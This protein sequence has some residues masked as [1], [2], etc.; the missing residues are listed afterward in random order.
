MRR[1]RL[2]ERAVRRLDV[3]RRA[4]AGPEG[5]T[6]TSSPARHDAAR[7]LARVAAVVVVLVA[8][9]ADHPLHGEAAVVEVAVAGE[10]DRLEVLEQRRPVVPRR[11]A[12]DALD[13]VVAAQRRHRDDGTSRTPSRLARASRKLGL[14]L[15]EALLRRSRRG[16]SC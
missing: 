11:S 4:S 9:R 8:H 3:P 16:P 14:D 12:S 1:H 6:T 15:A 10:L 5:R 2:V 13:D 7:D